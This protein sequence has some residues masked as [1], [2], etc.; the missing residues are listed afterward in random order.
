MK[1]FEIVPLED[2]LGHYLWSLVLGPTLL[3]SVVPKQEATPRCLSANRRRLCWNYYSLSDVISCFSS[4]DLFYKNRLA[5]A[6]YRND[7]SRADS[8]CVTSSRKRHDLYQRLCSSLGTAATNY[9]DSCSARAARL[10]VYQSV[11]LLSKK[12]KH[13]VIVQV[14]MGVFSIGWS[15]VSECLCFQYYAYLFDCNNV[16]C[17]SPRI[18]W[19]RNVCLSI[20]TTLSIGFLVAWL[21]SSN[22]RGTVPGRVW[23]DVQTTSLSTMAS[24]IVPERLRAILYQRR[25]HVGSRRCYYIASRDNLE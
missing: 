1:S 20:V 12:K 22:D 16:T 10:G 5:L 17:D 15:L 3:F 11:C 13:E 7:A 14:L 6:L 4:L 23:K 2:A 19:I 18:S 24:S 21:V 9:A 25:S 8:I